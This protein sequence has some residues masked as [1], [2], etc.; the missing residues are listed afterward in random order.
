MKPL[1]DLV[2]W[3]LQRKNLYTVPANAA[4]TFPTALERLRSRSITL[5]SII[6]VGASDGRW[7]AQVLPFYPK[8]RYLCIEAHPAHQ[9]AL[10]AF[11]AN[12]PEVEYAICAAA[13]QEGQAWFLQTEDLLGGAVQ[14]SPY[15]NNCM[16]VPSSTV[17]LLVGKHK[18][19]PPFL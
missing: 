13:E 15:G 3:Y 5:G 1:Q 2:C 4:A 12:H 19:P 17:D 7:T 18:L 9:Q 6:D 8:A 16:T 10:S 14:Q 11:S